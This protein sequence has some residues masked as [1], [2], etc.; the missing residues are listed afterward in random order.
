MSSLNSQKFRSQMLTMMLLSVVAWAAFVIFFRVFWPGSYEPADA[1]NL[2]GIWLACGTL[3]FVASLFACYRLFKTPRVWRASAA[4]ALTAPA[5]VCDV[6]TITFF[7]RWYPD[8]GGA[9]DRYYAAMIVGAVG[10]F[11][12]VALHL[13]TPEA[14]S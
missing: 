10:V 4:L 5:L 13:A 14:D 12:L 2:F 8:G 3:I 6:F 7:E 1:L 11:Q 9:D